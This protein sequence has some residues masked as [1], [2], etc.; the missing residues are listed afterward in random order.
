MSSTVAEAPS[1][2]PYIRENPLEYYAL[3]GAYVVLPGY[4][5][6]GAVRLLWVGYHLV[7]L[8]F[9]SAWYTHVEEEL[10]KSS[11]SEK[12]WVQY[13][14]IKELKLELG[15]QL[16][17]AILELALPMIGAMICLLTDIP[18]AREE[19]NSRGFSNPNTS[20]FKHNLL[21]WDKVSELN[22][23]L[24]AISQWAGRNGD[25]LMPLP[26]PSAPNEEQK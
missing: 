9:Y 16:V 5:A 13:R 7:K 8:Q 11:D 6:A 25:K 20:K 19:K 3:S 17:R 4:F 1:C 22:M 24:K 10:N 14:S 23:E 2:M 15:I 21:G 26:V 18:Y 12:A